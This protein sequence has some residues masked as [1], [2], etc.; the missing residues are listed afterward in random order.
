MKSRLVII[1]CAGFIFWQLFMATILGINKSPARIM[2]ISLDPRSCSGQLARGLGMKLGH[3]VNILPTFGWVCYILWYT[4]WYTI[5][6]RYNHFVSEVVLCCD[7]NYNLYFD[8][9]EEAFRSL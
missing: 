2:F 9:S 4:I 1:E 6:I 5:Y 3:S 8:H 7:T